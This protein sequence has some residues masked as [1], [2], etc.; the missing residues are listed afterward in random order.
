MIGLILTGLPALAEEGLNQAIENLFDT[1]A[2]DSHK[3]ERWFHLY[4]QGKIAEADK[5]WSAMLKD[6]AK[7]PSIAEFLEN[8]N[9]RC[10][11]AEDENNIKAPKKARLDATKI[12]EH[13]LERTEKELGKEH[14]FCGDICKFL[15]MYW[16]S[17]KD[18]KKSK[19]YRLRE[20]SLHEKWLGPKHEITLLSM[21]ALAK[22]QIK[23]K[24]NEGAEALLKKVIAQSDE[25]RTPKRYHDGIKMYIEFLKSTGR[26]TDAKR[27][28][29]KYKTYMWTR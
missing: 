2:E 16:E 18:Y 3:F 17:Q 20:Y 4:S 21:L 28:I 6:M 22:L 10:W 19:T 14:R 7:M 9:S 29:A 26:D 5:V 12:Y 1:R 25:V 24:E 13:L 8:I 15:A 11:F 23:M 27:V